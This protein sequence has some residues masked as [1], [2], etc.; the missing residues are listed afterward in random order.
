M[1]VLNYTIFPPIWFY[2]RNFQYN[3]ALQ[4]FS[5]VLIYR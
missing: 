1:Y 2:A 5:I 3:K 4:K